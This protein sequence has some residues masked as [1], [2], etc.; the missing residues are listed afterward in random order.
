[1]AAETSANAKAYKTAVIKIGSNTL[2]DDEGKCDRAY[3]ADLAHQVARVR[4]EGWRVIIVSSGAIPC[5]LEA[6][7]LPLRRP[8]DMPTVQA[9]ASVGQRALL[10]AYDQ[11][12]SPYGMLT[13]LV[14]LTRRDTADRNAYLH[15]RDTFRRLVE[16]ECRAYCERK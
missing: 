2:T 6:L 11:V 13:S 8:D 3:L 9:A 15:A 10:A 12:F 14:L 7:G 5:G 16:V 1:M 4:R